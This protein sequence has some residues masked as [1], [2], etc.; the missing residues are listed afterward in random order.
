MTITAWRF[1]EAGEVS[2][3][4]T[5]MPEDKTAD[6]LTYDELIEDPRF[7][8][9]ADDW[10]ARSNKPAEVATS[11]AIQRQSSKRSRSENPEDEVPQTE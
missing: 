2:L 5:I 3:A 10:M 7:K 6:W 8:K 11:P 4:T 1:N 9:W